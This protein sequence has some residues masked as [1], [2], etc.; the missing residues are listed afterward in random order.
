[1]RA[2]RTTYRGLEGALDR[3]VPNVEWLGALPNREV[4]SL[5]RDEALELF[6]SWAAKTDKVEY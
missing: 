5:M 1:M 2:P 6:N 3:S 4:L